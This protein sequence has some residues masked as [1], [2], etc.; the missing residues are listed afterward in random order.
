M[1]SCDWRNGID[2]KSQNSPQPKAGRWCE[3]TLVVDP[4]SFFSHVSPDSFGVWFW[5]S[6]LGAPA[7]SQNPLGDDWLMMFCLLQSPCFVTIYCQTLNTTMIRV[8]RLDSC[9]TTTTAASVGCIPIL[10]SFFPFMFTGARAVSSLK[11]PGTGWE[12]HTQLAHDCF[13]EHD[14]KRYRLWRRRFSCWLMGFLQQISDANATGQSP[15]DQLGPSRQGQTTLSRT[16]QPCCCLCP[17]PLPGKARS[18]FHFHH[19]MV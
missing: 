18:S 4:F 6:Q 15:V 16:T 7:R 10:F 2:T 17:I 11:L 19:D 3:R 9:S 8:W 13:L 1:T 14:M 12:T 5:C